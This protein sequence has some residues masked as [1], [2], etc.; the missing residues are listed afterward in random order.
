MKKNRH[1]WLVVLMVV[2]A[3]IIGGFIGE[4]LAQYPFFKWMSFGADNGYREIMDIDLRPLLDTRVLSFGFSLALRINA[5]SVIA[6][7]IAII[8]FGRRK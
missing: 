3:A 7:I 4:Y 8:I 6:M 2:L 5:G 1:L